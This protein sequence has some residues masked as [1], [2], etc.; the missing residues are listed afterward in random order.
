VGRNARLGEEVILTDITPMGLLHTTAD[1]VIVHDV[2][3]VGRASAAPSRVFLP[4]R[5]SAT[6]TSPDGYRYVTGSADAQE[7][8]SMRDFREGRTPAFAMLVSGS[9]DRLVVAQ[10]FRRFGRDIWVSPDVSLNIDLAAAAVEAMEA[11][12]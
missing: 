10:V 7:P 4:R 5:L 3:V 11:D 9:D 8:E 1:Q 12:L 2:E 6:L